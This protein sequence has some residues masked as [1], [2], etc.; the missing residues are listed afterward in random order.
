LDF[1]VTI[2]GT[3]S[4][5]PTLTRNQSGHVLTLRGK[6]YLIDCGEN[7]QA[8]ILKYQLSPGK[9]EEVFITHLH[10]DHFTGLIGLISSQNLQRRTAPLTIYSPEGLKE[11]IEVQLKHSQTTLN[12]PLHFETIIT[13]EYNK[14]FENNQLEVYSIPLDHRVPCS[15][16]LFREKH[17]D[18]KIN[19]E[20]IDQHQVPV[21]AFPVLKQGKDYQAPDGS[22]YQSA[23]YTFP[24]PPPRSY[25]YISD[26]RF[27]S[28]IGNFL[29][30]VDLLYHEATFEAGYQEKAN[31]T[32]HTTTEEAA[33]M[34]QLTGVGRLIIGHYSARYRALEKLRDEARTV[35]EETYLAKEGSTFSILYD[36]EAGK[37][38]QHHPIEQLN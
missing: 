29:E 6:E 18:K 15:G 13:N 12:F 14:I 10:P 8:Q 30:G 31:K 38:N 1:K 21:D 25:A 17:E 2:L 37:K 24:P 36:R 27:L 9:I 35:F 11:I 34:A 32:Y 16:F 22:V 7:I 20:A 28:E 5:T 4:A 19:K 3:S 33:K 26:T 23:T